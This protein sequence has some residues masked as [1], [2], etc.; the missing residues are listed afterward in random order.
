[1]T[2]KG[3][4]P[5]KAD[6]TIWQTHQHSIPFHDD[7]NWKGTNS[8]VHWRALCWEHFRRS[9][10]SIF[11]TFCPRPPTPPRHSANQRPSFCTLKFQSYNRTA[12]FFSFLLIDTLVAYKRKR[13]VRQKT[14]DEKTKH[15]HNWHNFYNLKSPIF[16]NLPFHISFTNKLCPS[17]TYSLANWTILIT[18]LNHFSV[19]NSIFFVSKILVNFLTI[20]ACMLH[21]SLHYIY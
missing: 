1:M 3:K 16:L 5:R 9:H 4:V 14:S 12:E 7:A 15:S 20:L 11:L 6:R 8:L 21:A 2:R 13:R 18:G 10:S 17:K 19:C